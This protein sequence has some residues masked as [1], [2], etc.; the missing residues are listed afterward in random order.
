M[1]P[2][3]PSDRDFGF[4]PDQDGLGAW[5]TET[6][7]NEDSPLANPDHAHLADASIGWL[8]TSEPATHRGRIILGE[9]RLV[10]PQQERWGSAMQHRQIRDW[11]GHAPDFIIT[12]S[13]PWA[14]QMDDA[15]FCALVEH[16]MYHAAQA[17][18]EYGQPRFRRDGSPMFAL[19]GHDV[20]EFIGVVERYGV[21]DSNV[22]LLVEAAQRKPTVGQSDLAAACGTCHLKLAA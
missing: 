1:R 14:A 12:L 16:E 17:M 8:W 9:C 10:Q 2:L 3:P 13:A 18:D 15:T 6:F 11:F 22:A 4:R 19:R 21:V 5:V 7:I 20:E